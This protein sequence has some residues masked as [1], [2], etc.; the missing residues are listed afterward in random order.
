MMQLASVLLITVGV[1]LSLLMPIPVLYDFNSSFLMLASVENMFYFFIGIYF[2]M[3]LLKKKIRLNI[4]TNEVRSALI[5]TILL[6]ILFATYFYNLGLITNRKRVFYPFIFYVIA[7]SYQLKTAENEY[8]KT[9]TH[10]NHS[11]IA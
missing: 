5:A 7:M 11:F 8:T 6:I 9:H 3:L 1:L 2:V 4:Y 10:Y